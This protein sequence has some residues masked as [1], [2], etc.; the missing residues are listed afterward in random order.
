MSTKQWLSSSENA[1]FYRIAQNQLEALYFDTRCWTKAEIFE[2]F[3]EL[4]YADYETYEQAIRRFPKYKRTDF[5]TLMKVNR[6]CEKRY[7]KW[8]REQTPEF[9]EW[10]D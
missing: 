5:R 7:T 1:M 2:F 9:L 6:K 8:K 10:E 4:R 3:D